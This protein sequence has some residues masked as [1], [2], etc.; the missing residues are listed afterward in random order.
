[1]SKLL[2][3]ETVTIFRYL[4]FVGLAV[5]WPCWLYAD[6]SPA[7]LKQQVLRLEFKNNGQ[8]VVA[9]VGER[10]EI[11]LGSIGPGGYSDP[12]ISSAAIRLKSTNLKGIPNPG[13][14][15]YVYTFE[16]AAEGKARI[17]FSFVSATNPDAVKLRTFTVT[18]RVRRG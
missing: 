6:S 13:G 17:L 15:T 4:V 16:A 5:S 1:V 10:I 14:P 3:Y 2:R 9:S 18:I 12:Q 7:S 11:T 8:H